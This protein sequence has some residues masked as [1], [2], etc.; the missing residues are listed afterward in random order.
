MEHCTQKWILHSVL[1]YKQKFVHSSGSRGSRKNIV[2]PLY[3]PWNKLKTQVNMS[4]QNNSFPVLK[5]SHYWRH[6]KAVGPR[7]F[8]W[9]DRF[10]MPTQSNVPTTWC[11]LVICPL[12]LVNRE[13][14]CVQ[15]AANV[16]VVLTEADADMEHPQTDGVRQHNAACWCQQTWQSGQQQ[17]PASHCQIHMVKVQAEP[18]SVGFPFPCPA[19]ASCG[20]FH[21]CLP[22]V[23]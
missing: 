17:G 20:T 19:L 14:E 3:C 2:Y 8:V 5:A 10:L 23:R 9:T 11:S 7:H 13:K 22:I 1:Q 18:Y 6:Y 12:N 4:I 15:R 16:E 21:A